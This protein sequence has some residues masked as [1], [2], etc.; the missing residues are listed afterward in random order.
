VS[1][2]DDHGAITRTLA[3]YCR[4]CDDGRFE[5]FGEL[6]TAD[7]VLVIGGVETRGR[8]AIRAEVARRQTPARR[9]RHLTGN[10]VVDR[11]GDTA[12]VESDFVFFRPAPDGTFTATVVGRY[13]D[14]L[15]R[16]ER[17][18]C[19]DRREIVGL[20]PPAEVSPT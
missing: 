15:V 7:A 1:A 17:G 2:T 18:W 12:H 10:V 3:E 11:R 9:G 13:L 4:R 6:F 14:D 8:E 19:F 5:V 20:V 16:T